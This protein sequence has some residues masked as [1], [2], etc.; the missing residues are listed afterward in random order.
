MLIVV[1]HTDVITVY[2][3]WSMIEPQIRAEVYVCVMQTLAMYLCTSLEYARCG[4]LLS[5][6]IAGCGPDH[7]KHLTFQGLTPCKE[8]SPKSQRAG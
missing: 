3:Y 4:R 7:G 5:Q 6:G 8:T 1:Q 2:A